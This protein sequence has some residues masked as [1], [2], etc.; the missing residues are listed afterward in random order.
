GLCPA[1]KELWMQTKR[2]AFVNRAKQFGIAD[3]GRRGRLPIAGNFNGDKWPDLFTGQAEG[4]DHPSPNR[5]WLNVRGRR[6]VN[7]PGLPTQE[8]GNQCVAA[9]DFDGD[10]PRY[11]DLMVCGGSHVQSRFLVYDN[12]HGK[13]SLDN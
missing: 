6:F 9:G 11:E 12:D 4:V 7:P 3:P 5:L 2:G 13:W 1:S 10:G 8:I